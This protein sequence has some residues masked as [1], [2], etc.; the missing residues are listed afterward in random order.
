MTKKTR[1]KAKQGRPRKEG[2]RYPSGQLKAKHSTEPNPVTLARR[3]EL[4]GDPDATSAECAKAENPLD[5]MLE[6]GWISTG[7]WSAA[8]WYLGLHKLAKVD[9]PRVGAVDLNRTSRGVDHSTGDPEAMVQLRAVWDRLRANPGAASELSDLALHDKFPMWVLWWVE[10]PPTM[11]RTET[12][13]LIPC[14]VRHPFGLQAECSPDEEMPPL[15]RLR[16]EAL[17]RALRMV[18]EE[19]ISTRPERAKPAPTSAERERYAGPKVEETVVYADE[20][21][22]EI[23]PTESQHGIPFELVRRRRA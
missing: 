11:V 1:R 21:T 8:R 6:R 23:V 4:L 18:R 12:D 16:R 13:Q 2:A 22:G 9:L 20:E 17:F 15:Y 19:Q 14:A 5:L 3:R 7:L 10:N